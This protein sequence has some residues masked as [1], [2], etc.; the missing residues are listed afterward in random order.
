MQNK[1][2]IDQIHEL[3]PKHLNS[4]TNENWK[5][6]V[7]AL[8]EQD[9]N[10][11]DLVSQ[12][13]KQFFIKTAS[14]PYLDRLA[15]NNKIARP[16]L[17]GMDDTSF[18]QY[19]PVLSYQPKQVK[20]IIDK[21]L[22]IF[23]FKESTTAFVTSTTFEPFALNDGWELELSVDEQYFDRVVF[24]SSDFTNINAASANEIVA[25]INRQAKY[26]YAT[27][28][29]DSITKNTFI[30]FFTNTIGS[31]GSLR[32]TGG[33]ANIALK[34]DGF[35][36]DAGNGSNTEWLVTK[37]GNEITFKY[38]SGANP[39]IDKL[40]EEDLIIINMPENNG[41]FVIKSVDLVE[42]SIKFNSIFGST[43]VFT[44]TNENN[45]KFIRPQKF[46]A[47][48]NPRRAIVWETTSGELTVEMPTSPPVVKRSL[49]GSIHINGAFSQMSNR[50]SDTSLKVVNALQ[51]PE[52]GT[53]LIE[54][55]DEI[56][57]RIDTISENEIVST[58]NNTRLQ[59]GDQLYSYSSRVSL[60]TT[61]N[62]VSGSNQIVNL[63]ST[64]G[65]NEGD[66]VY[67]S[68]FP[69]Y[70]VITSITGSIVNTSFPATGTTS[71]APVKFLGNTLTGITPNL[72]IASGLNELTLTS[73]SRNSNIIN[74]TTLS[75]HGYKIGDTMVISGS[76]GIQVS[77][78]TGDTV[79]NSNIVSNI[80]NM[81][82]VAPGI[83]VS[84]P[85]IPLGSMILSSTANTIT[86]NQLVTSTVVSSP[87]TLS[88][89]LN[90]GAVLTTASGN[91]FSF[92][93][94]GT[95]GSATIPGTA[96]T[97]RM[98][99]ASS[100]S[101]IIITNAI[102]S[103]V[104][105]ILGTYMWDKAATFVLSSN[106]ATINDAIKA[107]KIIRLIN[108]SINSI[109]PNGGYLIFDYGRN[110]QEG[111]VRFL[112][113]PTENTIAIDPSYTFKHNHE[114]GSTIVAINKKGP[115]Q[116]SN[117]AAEYSAYITDPSEARFILQDLI[118]SVKSAGIFVNFL[119]RYPE[120]IFGVLDVYN[121]QG[122]GAGEPFK[123]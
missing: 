22:D 44:Q 80:S 70:T 111:P 79:Q 84:G 25:T 101:K 95:N 82:G 55:V 32:I 85:G 43:G 66:Q 24:K 92:L 38:V 105:R 102:P 87:I 2:K 20:L 37:I 7:E 6:V 122:L 33:R 113:K 12:V 41:S 68:V 29:Y 93:K 63:A 51:F 28:Y 11:A 75:P 46:V 88:E 1:S 90:A 118:R 30:R 45:M 14:R 3:L 52:S 47:Y 77:T 69:K 16:R 58:K 116:V 120:Q 39:G 27:S 114:V 65:I 60:I 104:S 48:L 21:L 62:T 94:L 35:I 4:K 117:N 98:G 50:I 36:N 18:R 106:T 97:E 123:Q 108:T 86:I 10:A 34:F 56:I 74:G 81:S 13:R 53:F 73:L 5:A 83:V 100:G 91:T 64:L 99:L 72:P 19:I 89:N 76:S 57:Q 8:G 119:I 96:R 15:S 107:G 23:F 31:K 17:V 109:S 40:Q 110:N 115:H 26:L 9:Q 121:Q 42:S 61:G 54:R 78:T 103:S 59:Y 71:S 112:Y 49:K 67:S